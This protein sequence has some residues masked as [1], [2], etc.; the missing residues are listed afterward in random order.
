M[1]EQ[2]KIRRMTHGR[3][4]NYQTNDP[5]LIL[6][7]IREVNGCIWFDFIH[8]KKCGKVTQRLFYYDV[9]NMFWR[10]TEE[11][12]KKFLK[13]IENRKKHREKETNK[14]LKK[15]AKDD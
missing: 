5:D 9:P 11:E 3:K 14:L 6:H 8:K 4:I 2:Q 7:A 1:T 13:M 12:Y 10:G 15:R